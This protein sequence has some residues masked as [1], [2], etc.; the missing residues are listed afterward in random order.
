VLV[1]LGVLVLL[2]RAQIRHNERLERHIGD[3]AGSLSGVTRQLEGA[4]APRSG[5]STPWEGI[6]GTLDLEEVLEG[7]LEAASAVGPLDGSRVSVPRP[8]GT[9]AQQG[10]GLA[11]TDVASTE[12]PPDGARFLHGIHAWTPAEPGSIQSGL[13]VPLAGGTLGVYS[14]R[15]AAFD[16]NDAELLAAIAAGVAPAVANAIEHLRVIAEAATDVHTGFGSARALQHALPVAVSTAHRHGRPLCLIQIDLDDFGTINRSFGQEGGDLVLSEFGRRTL[17]TKRGSDSVFR[18]S[19]GADEFFFLLA[20]T[21]REDA[22]T[23]YRRVAVEVTGRPF[24]DAG[25][26]TMSAGLVELRPDDSAATLLR[27]ADALVRRAKERGKNRLCC[28][29]GDEWVPAL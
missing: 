23:S 24:E 13:V 7:I 8:D 21:E 19:G 27:R 28:D 12:G 11:R 26:V 20:D 16:A 25:R 3:L 18:N 17:A 22:K 15:P 9:L 1:L 14:T 6:H 29:D 4:L 2:V 5:L 10:R